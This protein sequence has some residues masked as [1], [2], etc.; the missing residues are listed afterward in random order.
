MNQYNQ[1]QKFG[2]DKQLMGRLG[3]AGEDL[4]YALA[5]AKKPESSFYKDFAKIRRN[6]Y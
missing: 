4:A 2:Q 6:R 1:I 3:E 5:R